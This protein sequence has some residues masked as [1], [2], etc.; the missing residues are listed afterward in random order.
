MTSVVDQ[1]FLFLRWLY[2]T[3]DL[4]NLTSAKLNRQDR[5]I[6]FVYLF[7]TLDSGWGSVLLLQQ[8]KTKPSR[9][10]G[11]SGGIKQVGGLDWIE[12]RIGGPYVHLLFNTV[13]NTVQVRLFPRRR[14]LP[15]PIVYV[16]VPW[17]KFINTNGRPEEESKPD[18]STQL[19]A[20]G[21]LRLVVLEV[22]TVNGS[23]SR[24]CSWLCRK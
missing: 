3:W 18:P 7:M 14:V 17:D 20:V 11:Y 8:Q 2:V 22:N 4:I 13:C 12:L 24:F 15:L 19:V 21:T 10:N 9:Q 16:S 5:L 6:M 23:S 1:V